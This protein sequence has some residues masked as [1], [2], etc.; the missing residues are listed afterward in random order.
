MTVSGCCPEKMIVAT[1]KALMSTLVTDGESTSGGSSPR[2]LFT[3]RCTSTDT[4]SGLA[5]VVNCTMTVETPDD[6]MEVRPLVSI[7]GSVAIASSMGRVTVDS[8][9]CGS[10]PGYTVVTTTWGKFT[11]GMIATPSVE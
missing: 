1:P 6:E 9:V 2:A 4:R 8:T 3:T 7:F 11:F 10:A 5:A